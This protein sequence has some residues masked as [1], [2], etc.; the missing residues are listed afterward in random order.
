MRHDHLAS[1]ARRLRRSGA[2]CRKKKKATLVPATLTENVDGPIWCSSRVLFGFGFFGFFFRRSCFSICSSFSL[3]PCR[4]RYQL[5]VK[6]SPA[7]ERVARAGA[8]AGALGGVGRDGGGARRGLETWRRQGTQ[9]DGRLAA[10]AGHT[11]LIFDGRSI[12][13]PLFL[14]HKYLAAIT[15]MNSP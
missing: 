10:L 7:V 2:T 6:Q 13:G 9:R 14:T 8:C 11:L 5:C 15:G 12:Q 4:V 3:F 1:P